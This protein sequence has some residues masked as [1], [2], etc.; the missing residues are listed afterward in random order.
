MIVWIC[1]HRA[2]RF[3]VSL[4]FK[5]SELK[6]RNTVIMMFFIFY[7]FPLG[8]RFWATCSNPDIHGWL[9]SE[10]GRLLEFSFLYINSRIIN[11]RILKNMSEYFLFSLLNTILNLLAL[12]FSTTSKFSNKKV[13][14]LLSLCLIFSWNFLK[15]K[16]SYI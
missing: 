1:K 15:Y 4:A 9:E 5:Q 11:A 8:E 2:L 16:N 3:V 6:S 10:F 7:F 13:F 12:D 14:W